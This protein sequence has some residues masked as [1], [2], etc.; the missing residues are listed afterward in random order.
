MLSQRLKIIRAASGLSLR[1]LEERIDKLVTAQA[2]SN[3]ERGKSTPDSRV[4]MALAD[5]L[6][7][8]VRYLMRG[9]QAAAGAGRSNRSALFGTLP[10]SGGTALP[11]DGN[12]EQAAG[13]A[14]AGGGG[15]R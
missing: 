8:S 15:R 10:F 12:V 7:V 3:Y 6:G 5:A 14:V 13:G 2:I 1:D 4:L 11:A 9:Q